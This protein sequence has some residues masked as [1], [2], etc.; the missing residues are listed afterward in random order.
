MKHEKSY[1]E[2]GFNFLSTINIKIFK[3]QLIYR[4]F[5][6]KLLCMS[7]LTCV[8]ATW[9]TDTRYTYLSV[10]ICNSLRA[11]KWQAL[12]KNIVRQL[13]NPQ[14]LGAKDQDICRLSK[15]HSRKAWERV[16][17]GNEGIGKCMCAGEFRKPCTCS[18]QDTLSE[19]E[20]EKPELSPLVTMQAR[21]EGLDRL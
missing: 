20:T 19:K 21:S 3:T 4:K 1:N 14:L 10:H 13:K 16:S 8:Q 15:S 9:R 5:R 6:A 11:E 12:L 17:L 18:I 7:I 2:V